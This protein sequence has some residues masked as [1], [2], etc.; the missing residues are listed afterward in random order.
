MVS[1]TVGRGAVLGAVTLSLLV[2]PAQAATGGRGAAAALPA[3][4][5]AGVDGVL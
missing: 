4:D 2:V 1:A 5:T 3:P